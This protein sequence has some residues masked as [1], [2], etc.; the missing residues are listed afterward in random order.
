MTSASMTPRTTRTA[1]RPFHHAL[2]LLLVCLSVQTMP[3]TVV[4]GDSEGAAAAAGVES[5]TAKFASAKLTTVQPIDSKAIVSD[6]A[7]YPLYEAASRF[8]FSADFRA[9]AAKHFPLFNID[10]LQGNWQALCGDLADLY[11]G[12]NTQLLLDAERARDDV[13]E[14]LLRYIT[15]EVLPVSWANQRLL[16]EEEIN[17]TFADVQFVMDTGTVKPASLA[18]VK[19]LLSTAGR[20]QGRMGGLSDG[21]THAELVSRLAAYKIRP[22]TTPAE[23]TTPG[24]QTRQPSFLQDCFPDATELLPMPEPA[25]VSPEARAA[26]K[27]QESAL[28]QQAV[29]DL[30]AHFVR[31]GNPQMA[32]VLRQADAETLR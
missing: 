6:D 24:K 26:M 32:E 10:S 12:S 5:I 9:M 17:S 22:A 30:Q 2:G 3:N 27:E 20:R 13:A 28:C 11:N 1:R 14:N 29:L 18:Y 8:S 7:R 15:W 21:I 4:A 19:I 16:T 25:F 31:E 23:V